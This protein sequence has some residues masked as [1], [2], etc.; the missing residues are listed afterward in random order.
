MYNNVRKGDYVSYEPVK[1]LMMKQMRNKG[2]SYQEIGDRM[3]CSRQNVHQILRGSSGTYRSSG[4]LEQYPVL[5]Q[6]L[7]TYGI[8][9]KDFAEQCSIRPNRFYQCLSSKSKTEFTEK[10]KLKIKNRLG[11][12]LS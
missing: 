2:M 11:T 7:Y 6:Y 3:N 9:I 4:L 12:E 5:R 8:C 1:R 10:E